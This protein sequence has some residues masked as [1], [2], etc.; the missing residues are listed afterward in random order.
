[1][2]KELWRALGVQDLLRAWFSKNI[3]A[4]RAFKTGRAVKNASIVG[5]RLP[6][7]SRR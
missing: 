6:P 3:T 5:S 1:M 2:A 4:L 7:E